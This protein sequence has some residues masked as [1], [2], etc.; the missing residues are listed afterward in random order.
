MGYEDN[1]YLVELN[2]LGKDITDKAKNFAKNV[3]KETYNT[4]EYSQNEENERIKNIF[5]GKI[6]EEIFS[7]WI[8]ENLN[9]KL[10]INYDIYPGVENVDEWDF[11]KGNIRID[12][13]SSKDTKNEGFLNCY[14]YFNFPVL[15][16]QNIKDISIS[17][18]YDINYE[19]FMIVSWID[20]KTYE[21]NYNIINLQVRPGI[22]KKY[23]GYKLKEGKNLI[24][25][26]SLLK[27]ELKCQH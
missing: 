9:M 20:K 6:A 2:E 7:K 4:F 1:F 25:L 22:Y 24:E 16:S 23:H 12:I 17:I 14:N 19:K 8:F 10:D 5:V 21:S 18:L 26:K 27:E 11:K 15:L 3:V 13:K